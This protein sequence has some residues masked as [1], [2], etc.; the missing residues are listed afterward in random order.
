[1]PKPSV[2]AIVDDDEAVREALFDLLL[3]DGLD[4]RMF[5]GAAAFL[6]D[7]GARDFACVVTDVRMPEIGG[8]EL[9]RRLRAC[10]SPMPVIFVTSCTDEAVRACALREGAIAWFAKPVDDAALLAMLRSVVHGPAETQPR[11]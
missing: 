5:G 6:S 7:A 4:A 8:L 9:Q 11:R 2:I 1:M 10:A 3:V